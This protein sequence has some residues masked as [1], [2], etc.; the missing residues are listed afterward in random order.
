LDWVN[1]TLQTSYPNFNKIPAKATA[2]ILNA[3]FGNERCPINSIIFED[4]TPGA[5]LQNAAKVLDMAKA[6]GF[7]GKLHP[8]KWLE[9]TDFVNELFF[10][11]WVRTASA[12]HPLPLTYDFSLIPASQNAAG[13]STVSKTAGIG[14]ENSAELQC[15]KHRTE[16]SPQQRDSSSRASGASESSSQVASQICA[17]HARSTSVTQSYQIS[18]QHL[19]NAPGNGHCDSCSPCVHGLIA[20]HQA[21]VKKLEERR[22]K[23]IKACLEK[24]QDVVLQLLSA[25]E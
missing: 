22:A 21:A 17:A 2:K 20:A 6:A 8:V 5:A 11:R 15:K 4:D 9:G 24:K 3:M 18:A 7:N 1:A 16:C 10:W 25:P 14:K 19:A 12:E 13:G 23:I